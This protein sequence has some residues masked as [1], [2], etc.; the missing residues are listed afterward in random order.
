MMGVGT[1]IMDIPTT[2]PFTN[3]TIQN[4]TFCGGSTKRQGD[5]L[6]NPC[7]RRDPTDCESQGPNGC[8]AADLFITNTAA[9]RGWAPFSSSGLYNVTVSNC[10][11][12]D[13]ISGHPIFIGPSLDAGQSVNDVLIITNLISS[14][15]VQITPFS[16]ATNFGDHTQCDNWRDL[17]AMEFADD[18]SA[19][20]PRNI[21]FDNNTFYVNAGAV[22]GL[23]RYVGIYN[24]HIN[25]YNWAS[26]GGGGAIEQES[27]SDQVMIT[28]NILLGNWSSAAGSES[29]FP[30][31]MELYGRNITVSGNTISGYAAEAIG[32]ISAY[33]P[34]VTGNNIYNNDLGSRQ[35]A[36]VNGDIKVKTVSTAKFGCTPAY[37]LNP[38][39]PSIPAMGPVSCDAFR[40][41]QGVTI[42]SNHSDD[43]GNVQYGIYLVDGSSGEAIIG[44]G[45]S[46]RIGITKISGNT[47]N[48]G[49]VIPGSLHKSGQVVYDPRLALDASLITDPSPS[50]MD[51]TYSGYD[52]NAASLPHTISIFPE[53][54]VPLGMPLSSDDPGKNQPPGTTRRFFRFGA[55]D[56][57]GAANIALI[58]GFF[59][60][61]ACPALAAASGFPAAPPKGVGGPYVSEP[62]AASGTPCNKDGQPTGPNVAPVYYYC[63]FAFDPPSNGGGATG[64]IYLDDTNPGNVGQW[65]AGNSVLGSAGHTVSNDFCAIH[66][67]T[68]NTGVQP[69]PMYCQSCTSNALVVFFD[70]ELIKNGTWFMYELAENKSAVPYNFNPSNQGSG[71]WS[72]WGYWKVTSGQ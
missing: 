61:A 43:L 55:N 1:D 71:V 36:F 17:H 2:I 56:P 50:P 8:G 27:C 6:G 42:K 70:I 47:L 69:A 14:G 28:D 33:A 22:S 18:P 60:T 3:V 20:P 19:G 34:T 72:L 15:G 65:K 25:G 54:S 48:V 11:F 63:S 57:A 44:D 39:Y 21:R 66:A 45:S 41:A 9:S 29:G 52:A 4:L 59:S 13:S 40:D 23:G 24:N 26:G 12:E 16:S 68:S 62:S 37:A 67:S 30:S 64:T 35:S 58:Q 53:G 5:L 31:G 38:A 7:P 10:L 46:N 32:I 51:S 49:D